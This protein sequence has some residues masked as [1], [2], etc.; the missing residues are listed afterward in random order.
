MKS[1]DGVSLDI[2][3]TVTKKHLLHLIKKGDFCIDCFDICGKYIV[4]SD[5]VDT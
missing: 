2:H 4:Y 3:S 1:S 5:C